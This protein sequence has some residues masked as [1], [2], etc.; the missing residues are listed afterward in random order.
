MGNLALLVLASWLMVC[1]CGGVVGVVVWGCHG[2]SA[3]RG[4]VALLVCLVVMLGVFLGH[5][6]DMLVGCGGLVGNWS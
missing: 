4:V 5:D 6:G 3:G 1:V 2:P